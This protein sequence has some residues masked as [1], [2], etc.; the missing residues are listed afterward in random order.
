MTCRAT[1]RMT[2]N[3]VRK[4]KRCEAG[5]AR[6]VFSLAHPTRRLARQVLEGSVRTWSRGVPAGSHPLAYRAPMPK[7]SDARLPAEWPP[8][9]LGSGYIRLGP[10]N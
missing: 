4:V 5:N 7:R 1:T 8:G 9:G 2:P 3:Y 6:S 10:S